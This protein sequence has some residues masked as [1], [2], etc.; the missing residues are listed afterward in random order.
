MNSYFKLID[1]HLKNISNGHLELELPDGTDYHY[2]YDSEPKRIKVNHTDFFSSLVLGGNIG[3]GEA[4]TNGDW[5]SD[6]LTGVLEL[7]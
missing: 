1:G 6:D 7:F 2:G 5:D 3:L 4:W